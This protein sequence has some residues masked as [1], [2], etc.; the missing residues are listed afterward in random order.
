MSTLSLCCVTD[1]SI[2]CC[3][4]FNGFRLCA[5]LLACCFLVGVFLPLSLCL[6]T[7][8]Q[9]C[10]VFIVG[11]EG[12]QSFKETWVLNRI[13]GSLVRRN[14]STTR[15]KQQSYLFICK[16]DSQTKALCCWYPW[17]FSGTTACCQELTPLDFFV[18]VLWPYK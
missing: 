1:S 16:K 11:E 7:A 14:D 6:V 9:K 13:S 5:V 4:S 12:L 18:V 17:M 10:W 8:K 3:V 2:R 15:F